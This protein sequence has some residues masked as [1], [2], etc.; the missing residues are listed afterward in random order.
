M[1]IE[2]GKRKIKAII[3]SVIDTHQNIHTYTYT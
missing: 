1:K 3:R 2:L